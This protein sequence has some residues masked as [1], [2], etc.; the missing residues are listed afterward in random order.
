MAVDF[1]ALNWL[2]L[3]ERLGGDCRVVLPLGATEQHGY[4]SLATDSLVVDRITAAAC[5]RADVVR[6]PVMPFACSA[7]AVNYPGTLSL[8]TVSFCHVVDDL[9][10]C[11][12][13]QGFRRLIVVTGHGGNEVITGVLSEVQVN[14]PNL[15]VRYV[16]ACAGMKD[17]IEKLVSERG[18]P[19][20]AHADWHE[21]FDFTQVTEIPLG[22]AQFPNDPDFPPFPLNPRSARQRLRSGVENGPYNLEDP[23]L[24][25]ELLQ[26]AIDGLVHLLEAQ[27]KSKP[28]D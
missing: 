1:H 2:Q 11:L 19:R 9:V 3:A 6:A 8:R 15:T 24:M 18:L 12:Y 23:A 21:V 27:P 25:N 26:D 4:L 28:A 14:R 10:D 17:R 13:R 5:E 16:D 20:P 7:F 22:C